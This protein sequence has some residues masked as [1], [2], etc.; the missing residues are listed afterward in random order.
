MQHDNSYLRAEFLLP[1]ILDTM[2]CSSADVLQSVSFLQLSNSLLLQLCLWW[3]D[4]IILSHFAWQIGL[5]KQRPTVHISLCLVLVTLS[6]AFFFWSVMNLRASYLN[7]RVCKVRWTYKVLY[8]FCVLVSGHCLSHSQGL[9][10][11]L[12]ISDIKYPSSLS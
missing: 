12:E 9:A 7:G 3:A 4:E 1:H 6:E 8:L 10:I 11:V 5:L 2:F